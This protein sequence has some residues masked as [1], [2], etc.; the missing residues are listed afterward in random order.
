MKLTRVPLHFNRDEFLTPFDRMFD[1]IVSS[2]F[3]EFEKN[4]GI[5]FQKGSFPKVDVA[6]YDESI[7]IIAEIPSLKKDALKIEVED[8]ILTISGDKHNLHDE[9]VR[10][11]RRELKHSSFRRSFQ[12]F[13]DLLDSKNITAN[14]EDGVLRIEIPKKSP[15]LPKKYK[16]DIL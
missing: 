5:S 16:V 6:D 1:D 7:V 14:F 10:Y 11:I 15:V 9:D 3:P 12:F 2:Q 4:F 8:N 13:N